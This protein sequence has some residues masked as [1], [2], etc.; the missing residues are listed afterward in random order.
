MKIIILTKER[1]QQLREM[2]TSIEDNTESGTYEIILCDNGSTYPKMIEYLS[3]LESKYCVLYNKANLLFEGFNIGL[4]K[5]TNDDFFILSDPDIVLN[6]NI[7]KNWIDLL[8]GILMQTKAPKVG[9][10]LRVDDVDKDTYSCLGQWETQT[11]W[12]IKM[13]ING[14]ECYKAPVDTTLAMYRRDTFSYWVNR[15]PQFHSRDFVVYQEYNRKY[16]NMM[17]CIRV[18][19]NFIAKHCGWY[20]KQYKEEMDYYKS[21]IVQKIS[22]SVAYF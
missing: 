22:S 18:G 21:V 10:A 15:Q 7:P 16:G 12:S 4:N 9:M 17:D 8:K 20:Y 14:I 2:L 13:M 19:G 6:K 3:S 5:I 11:M 1:P